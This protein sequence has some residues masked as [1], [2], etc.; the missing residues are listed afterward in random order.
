[1]DRSSEPEIVEV[2][3]TQEGRCWAHTSADSVVLNM[4]NTASS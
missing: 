4:K 2:T 1:M 3:T